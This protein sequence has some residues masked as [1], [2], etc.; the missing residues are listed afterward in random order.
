MK[1]SDNQ[2]NKKLNKIFSDIKSVKI[3]GATNIAKAA[4]SAYSL[5]PNKKTIAKLESLR[6]TE[7]MLQNVLHMLSKGKAKEEILS[8]FF[9][10]QDKINKQV[11][12][13]IHNSDAI[14]THCHSTAV[15]KSL[16]YS[17]QHAKHFEVYNTE[18]R[19]LYQGRKTAV[20]LG[21]AGIKV[22]TFVD[23]ALNIA[24]TDSQHQKDIKKVNKVFLGADAILKNGDVVNKVGSGTIAELAKDHKIPV[25]VIGDSWKFSKKTIGLEQRSYK[26]VWDNPGVSSNIK[27]KNPA[28]E[29]IPAKNITAI[30][31]D[32]GILS[33][34]EFI[35]KLK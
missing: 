28:F 13:L 34:R 35:K 21:N 14:F 9:Q 5:S 2:V 25:Y 11:F 7:P 4:I 32:L 29:K 16:I 22:K 20:E 10:A 24:L 33:P 3:Q 18:T 27:I 8:H 15:V 26:E 19:P 6:P 17:K 12:N 23:S 31:S 30:I 1:K